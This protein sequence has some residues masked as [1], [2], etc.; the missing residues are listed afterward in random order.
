MW[1]LYSE[2][3]D[4]GDDQGKIYDHK[5]AVAQSKH[6][7]GGNLTGLQARECPSQHATFQRQ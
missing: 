4:L 1:K 7:L 3:R 2:F 6:Y 5:V